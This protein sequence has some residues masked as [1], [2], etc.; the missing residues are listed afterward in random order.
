MTDS[1]QKRYG[2]I[3]ELTKQPTEILTATPG[4]LWQMVQVN[5]LDILMKMMIRTVDG[6]AMSQAP[7]VTSHCVYFWHTK[8][9]SRYIAFN[10]VM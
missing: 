6:R 2:A 8:Y 9:A 7:V 10:I 5:E 3:T 1:G 4:K